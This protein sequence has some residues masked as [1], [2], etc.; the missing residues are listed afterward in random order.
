MSPLRR[1]GTAQA[2]FPEDRGTW[3]LAIAVAATLAG[4][5]VVE[6]GPYGGPIGTAGA[7]IRTFL[8]LLLAAVPVVATLWA[9]KRMSRKIQRVAPIPIGV[10]AVLLALLAVAH[11]N[12][13]TERVRMGRDPARLAERAFAK[14]DTR[15]WA[16]EDSAYSIAAPPVANRCVMNKYGVREIP[17]TSGMTVNRAHQRYRTSATERALAYNQ[18]MI[19]R[20][21][22]K[23]EEVARV[24]DS[25]CPDD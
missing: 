17:G 3:L 6:R 2:G 18:V 11:A 7:V 1:R 15:F 25:Y 22:L 16:V 4:W 20:L 5:L 12:I 23:P 8:L 21:R 13:Y 24:A 10:L 14:G 19:R 9:W